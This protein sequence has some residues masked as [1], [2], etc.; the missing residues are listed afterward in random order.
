MI[1]F[2]QEGFETHVG[3]QILS[4]INAIRNPRHKHRH[5]QSGTS[6]VSPTTSSTLPLC[7][8]GQ[9]A[10]EMSGE[11]ETWLRGILPPEAATIEPWGVFLAEDLSQCALALSEGVQ[12]LAQ[13][14]PSQPDMQV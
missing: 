14:G 1:S 4:G 6:L 10:K 11:L 13:H 12:W 2:V 7:N 5:V 3:S 8:N 9:G